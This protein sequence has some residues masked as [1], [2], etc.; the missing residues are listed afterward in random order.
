MDLIISSP[1]K[2]TKYYNLKKVTLSS[3]SGQIQILPNHAETFLLLKKDKIS[4]TDINNSSEDIF[5]DSNSQC[6]IK[7]NKIIILI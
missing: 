4:L 6:Y 3:L 7:D 2:N 1:T 5:I